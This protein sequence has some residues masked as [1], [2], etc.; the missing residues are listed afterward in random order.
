MTPM[1]LARIRGIGAAIIAAVTLTLSAS[2]GAREWVAFPAASATTEQNPPSTPPSGLELR[3]QLFRPAGEGRFPAVVMLHDCRGIRPYQ[4]GWADKLAGWGYVALIVD[5]FMT[6]YDA[7][8]CAHLPAYVADNRDEDRVGDAV[9]ALNYLSALPFVDPERILIMG[10]AYDAVLRAVAEPESALAANKR[11]KAAIA[12]SPSCRSAFGKT[13]TTPA[14]LLVGQRDDWTPASD[15]R[16]LVAEAGN[17]SQIE[18]VV[19][20]N[21]RHGF[22]DPDLSEPLKLDD[23]W[24]PNR[25]GQRGVELAYDEDARADAVNRVREF[26]TRHAPSS[27][28]PA[29][30]ISSEAAGESRA[31]WAVDPHHPGVNLPPVGRSTF[32]HLFSKARNGEVVFELPFPFES[33]TAHIRATLEPRSADVSPIKQALIPLGRSLQRHAAAPDYFRFPRVVVAVDAEP[34]PRAGQELILL[35]DRL[36][37]GYQERS[38]TIEVISY[39]E[40]AGRFEFQLVKNYGPGTTPE[41]LYANR[42]ICISCHQNAGPIFA[43][44]PWDETNR[45]EGVAARLARFKPRFYGVP[46]FQGAGPAATI[47]ASTDRA[48][49]LPVYQRLWTEGCADDEPDLASRCRAGA[50]VAMLQYRLSAALHFDRESARY[51]DGFLQV[52]ARQWQRRWPH[53]LKVPNPDL[54][55]REPVFAHPDIPAIFDP[56]NLRP[57]LEIWSGLRPRDV[58]KLITGLSESIPATDLGRL[59]AFLRRAE[60]RDGIA[61]NAIE[62]DCSVREQMLAGGVI[63]LLIR[64]SP[65]GDNV[66]LQGSVRFRDG[67]LVDGSLDQ[68]SLPQGATLFQLTVRAGN[69][70]VD[71][72][73]VTVSLTPTQAQTGFR[74]RLADGSTITAVTLRYSLEPGTTAE[75]MEGRLR[76]LVS[77]DFRI[78]EEAVER[79]RINENK[80]KDGG[81]FSD[82]PFRSTRAMQALFRILGI[83]PTPWCCADEL[84]FPPARAE[85][86]VAQENVAGLDAVQESASVR[87]LYR[88]C[89][90]CHRSSDP[91]PPNFLSGDV[92]TVQSRL[93]QCAP[94]IFFRLSMWSLEADDRAVTPMPPMAALASHGTDDARWQH[95]P[96]LETLRDY[97]GRLYESESSGERAGDLLN[98]DY[99]KLRACISG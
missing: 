51:R 3:G 28:D 16:Q 25:P 63:R 22:D 5:S 37:L 66:G 17:E 85:S 10:W 40:L 26:L 96:E 68:L 45:N 70:L 55:N 60:S 33:L 9:G 72:D 23:A 30:A 56:L 31:Q 94:R 36:F 14:L 11:F 52:T 58:E 41:V 1:G 53:G 27:W 71:G 43:L 99:A 69:R 47:D 81:L 6:R 38:Q 98:R 20:S 74:P 86:G 78:V 92:A 64:C 77:E 84:L 32:D 90:G 67:A 91:V 19:Y 44:F 15:C 54:R 35:K 59:D 24:N 62:A 79:L 7:D 83:E 75:S 50:F 76:V 61:R 88:Y 42:A 97:A 93:R 49:L 73:A 46:A 87:M 95:S 29:Y 82:R 80:T 8:V 89:A 57:P 21:A 2:T 48:S 39:N 65:T 34:G 12:V 4:V 13:M 18:L